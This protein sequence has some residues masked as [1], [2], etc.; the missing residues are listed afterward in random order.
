M[1]VDED[2]QLNACE[3][4]LTGTDQEMSDSTESARGL[5][6]VL[7]SSMTLIQALTASQDYATIKSDSLTS[8]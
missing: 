5:P 8:C 6:H 2:D 1:V 3:D 7:L 4:V